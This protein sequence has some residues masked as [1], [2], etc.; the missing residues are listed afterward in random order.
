[1]MENEFFDENNAVKNSD[2]IEEA[3]EVAPAVA[4]PSDTSEGECADCADGVAEYEPQSKTER[5]MLAVYKNEQLSYSLRIASSAIVILTVYA[6]LYDLV[7]LLS[8]GAYYRLLAVLVTTGV[9]FVM[10]TVMRKILNAERPYE[11]LLFYKTAPR[12][13][14]GQSFP[15]R[16]VFSVFVIGSVLCFTNLTVGI[17]L[18]IAGVVLSL[19]R[20]L[21]GYHFIRDVVAGAVIGAVSG[22]GGALIFGLL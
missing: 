21:L 10:V 17:L 9:P 19:V 16:H 14:R 22:V 20:V 4:E 11:V 5:A 8:E 6:L 3:T 15:S 18:L 2:A 1:M 7:A 12:S 13:K